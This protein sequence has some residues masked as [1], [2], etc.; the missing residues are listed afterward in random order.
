MA[1]PMTRAAAAEHSQ[2]TVAAISSGL[3]IRPIGSS[4][5]IFARPS[6][7][8]PCEAIHHR[9]LDVAGTD[10]VDADVLSGIIEGRCSGEANDAA[11]RSG[12]GRAALDIRRQLKRGVAD[13]FG[14]FPRKFHPR[15][16]TASAMS[17][18]FAQG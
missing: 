1:W 17:F 3:P 14:F 2:T 8:P 11:F 18:F 9:R 12:V 13:T 4:A 15:C 7:V 10:G 6:A 16:S 5:M